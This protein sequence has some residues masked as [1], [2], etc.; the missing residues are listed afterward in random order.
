[1][2]IGDKCAKCGTEKTAFGC[3]ECD[4]EAQEQGVQQERKN[5]AANTRKPRK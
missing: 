4:S 2:A 1:M 5:R 3:P